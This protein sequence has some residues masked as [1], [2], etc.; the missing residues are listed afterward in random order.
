MTLIL[1]ALACVP[2]LAPLGA[3]DPANGVAAVEPAAPPEPQYDEAKISAVLA[4]L[5]A[6]DAAAKAEA[7]KAFPTVEVDE[8]ERR[9]TWE[10]K[11][12]TFGPTSIHTSVKTDM[13]DKVQRVIMNWE[14]RANDWLF[15]KR[16]TVAV[17][18]FRADVTFVQPS[19]HVGYGNISEW[20]LLFVPDVGEALTRYNIDRATAEKMADPGKVTVRLSGTKGYKDYIMKPWEKASIKAGLVLAKRDPTREDALAVLSARPPEATP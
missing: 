19:T 13:S 17:G 8:V 20:A 1:L 15:F 4:Q 5:S 12:Y 18:E 2:N 14:Y 6:D 3:N 9:K 7:F 11:G 16:A 10:P